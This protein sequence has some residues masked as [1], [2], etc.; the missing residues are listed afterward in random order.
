MGRQPDSPDKL[1]ALATV[2]GY[3]RGEHREKGADPGPYD[4]VEKSVY[5]QD[6]VLR[7]YVM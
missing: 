5:D 3:K 2:N 4:Y 6:C 7:R 1:F